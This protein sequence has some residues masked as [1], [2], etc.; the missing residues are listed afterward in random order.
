MFPEWPLPRNTE[1]QRERSFRPANEFVTYRR[2]VGVDEQLE[3][4]RRRRVNFHSFRRWFIT[5]AEA[6]DVSETTVASVVGNYRKGMTYGHY[7][8]GPG[9]DLLWECVE[10]VTRT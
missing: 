2:R 5:K 9:M 8:K 10:T 3:G 6:A 7:S 4:K 1:S